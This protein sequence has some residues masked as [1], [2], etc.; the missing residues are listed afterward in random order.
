MSFGH[1]TIAATVEQPLGH[2]LFRAG[3]V[4]CGKIVCG[5]GNLERSHLISQ[6]QIMICVCYIDY[7]F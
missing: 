4:G 6:M 2:S 5:D 3:M 7:D 1:L